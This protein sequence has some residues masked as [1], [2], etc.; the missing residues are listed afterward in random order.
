MMIYHNNW[1]YMKLVFP[2]ILLLESPFAEQ[3]PSTPGIKE[4]H[5]PDSYN[6]KIPRGWNLAGYYI[7]SHILCKSEAYFEPTFG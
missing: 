5:T 4:T 6:I 1:F 3:F 7:P 2:N